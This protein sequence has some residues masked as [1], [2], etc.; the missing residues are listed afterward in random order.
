LRDQ[1]ETAHLRRTLQ[2]TLRHY[3]DI[4]QEIRLE[5]DED[6]HCY[7]IVVVTQGNTTTFTT[8]VDYALLVSQEMRDLRMVVRQFEALGTPP[9]VLRSGEAE[10]V[11]KDFP[12]LLQ[13]VST[14]GTKDLNIQRYKGLGEMNPLQLWETTM[15][16]TRRTL[17]QVTIE[18]A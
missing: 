1:E 10:H 9:Y 11:A 18:D 8:V 14:A 2:E 12:E 7:R 17:L 13:A 16:P 4:L 15:D 6:Y 5:W 3:G